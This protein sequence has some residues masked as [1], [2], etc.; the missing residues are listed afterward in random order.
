MTRTFTILLCGLGGVFLAI[1]L[2][3]PTENVTS[4]LLSLVVTQVVTLIATSLFCWCRLVR[5]KRVSYSA[6]LF[7]WVV[8][9]LLSTAI[10]LLYSEGWDAFTPAYWSDEIG[11]KGGSTSLWIL[12]GFVVAMCVLPALLV[13]IYYQKSNKIDATRGV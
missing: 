9:G 10:I 2:T 5:Q 7:G 3:V 11:V 8:G 1:C 6:A 4:L 13:V 12:M